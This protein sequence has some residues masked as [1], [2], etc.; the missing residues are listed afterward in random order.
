MV[1]LQNGDIRKN[2]TTNG[3][4]QRHSWGTQKKKKKTK[5]KKKKKKKKDKHP[6]VR[7]AANCKCIDIHTY[8]SMP[9]SPHYSAKCIV[10]IA[11]GD[12]A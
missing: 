1:G 6:N 12:N 3:E 4:S 11:F 9:W 2:L 10:N 5:K 8:T 7:L